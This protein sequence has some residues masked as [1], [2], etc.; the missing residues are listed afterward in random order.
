MMHQRRTWGLAAAKAG[1][2][3]V[4]SIFFIYKKKKKGLLGRYHEGVN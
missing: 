1:T 4:T 2:M 3:I